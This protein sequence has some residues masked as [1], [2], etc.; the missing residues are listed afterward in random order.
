MFVVPNIL[1]FWP[2]ILAAFLLGVALRLVSWAPA[3][4]LSAWWSANAIFLRQI[5]I[6]AEE[7]GSIRPA[8]A[9]ARASTRVCDR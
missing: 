5:A 4:P 1:K 2:V 7:N 8:R 6:L 3:S 9:S